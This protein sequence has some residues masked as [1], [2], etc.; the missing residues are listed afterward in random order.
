MTIFEQLLEKPCTNHGYPV[1]HKLKDC[2]LFKRML[3]QPSRRKGGDRDKAV[4]KEQGAPPKDRNTFT[5]PDG[6]LMIFRGPEGDCIKC[7]HKVHLR[8]VCIAKSSVP[9]FLSRSNTPITFDQG[10]H[11]P[12]VPR[13][14]TYPLLVDPIV[15]NKR[16]TKVLMDGDSSLNI[17]YVE[18]FN[19]MGISWS[20]LRTS[21]FPFLGIV[22]SMRAYPLRNI[23]L[24]VTFGD[25]G[26]FR[27]E[28]LIFE[29]VDLRDCTTPSL[30]VRATPNSWRS[31][32][33][34]TSS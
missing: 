8:E 10:D 6:C 20:K 21:I 13:L 15:G 25:R 12:N 16:L 22:P 33:T 4:P 30:G 11:P 14:R 3:G 19:A 23:E 17:L 2:K 28:T 1:K 7:Q 31:P 34:P 26:N 9:K 29:V 5:D 27:T 32:T 24:P 18:T